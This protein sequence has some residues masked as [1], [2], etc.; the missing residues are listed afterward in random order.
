MIPSPKEPDFA[1]RLT[2]LFVELILCIA[3]VEFAIMLL[4]PRLAP[5]LSDLAGSIVDTTSLS[6]ITGP[7][8]IWRAQRL[9]LGMTSEPNFRGSTLALPL[10]IAIFG[11]AITALMVGETW[12]DL[13]K[14]RIQRFETTA[15]KLVIEVGHRM[16]V[17]M[18]G[19][20]GAKGLVSTRDFIDRTTFRQYFVALD[21]TVRHPGIRSMALVEAVPRTGLPAFGSRV[22]AS[23]DTSFRVR[24]TGTLPTALIVSAFEPRSLGSAILGLD[25]S[26]DSIRQS[27]ILEAATT[28]QPRLSGHVFLHTDPLHRPA[29]L[30]FAPVCSRV[31]ERERI[32]G[33][34]FTGAVYESYVVSELLS[35]ID[36][37]GQGEVDLEIFDG[38]DRD[39][40]NLVFDLDGRRGTRSPARDLGIRRT[41]EVAGRTLVLR[42]S[43][44]PSLLQTTDSDTPWEIAGLGL[45]LS[46]LLATL[47]WSVSTS[48]ARAREIAERRTHELRETTAEL[49]RTL[50]RNSNLLDS[51]SRHAVLSSSDL[52]GTILSANDVFCRISG[53][54]REELVGRNHRILSSGLHSREFWQGMHREIREGRAWR[55]DIRNRR[56]DGSIYWLDTLIIPYLDS[57]GRVENLQTI[58]FDITRRM[59]DEE[60]LRRTTSLLESVLRCSSEVAIVATDLGGTITLFNSGA[61][62][63][64]GYE[65]SDVV[66]RHSNV[67]LHEMDELSEFCRNLSEAEGKDLGG[68]EALTLSASRGEPERRE[69]NL[70]RKDG[71]KVPVSMVVTARLGGVDGTVEGFVM[72]SHD[73]SEERRREAELEKAKL[74]AEAASVAKSA[75][76]AN[77]SHEI[78]T[79]MN[80]VLGMTNVLL[81]KDLGPDQRRTAEVIRSSA[82]SLLALLNDILDFS[83]IEAGKLELESISFDL[84]DLLDEVHDLMSFRAAE[85]GLRLAT[86]FHE[87]TP[88]EFVGDPGRI[89]QILVNLV[90]NAVKFTATGEV[91]VEVGA[92]RSDPASASIRFGV[93]DTGVGIP[94]EKVVHLFQAFHQADSSTTRR[95]GG[96]GLGLAICRQLVDLMGGWIDAESEE[97]KGS[98]FRFEIPLVRDGEGDSVHPAESLPEPEPTLFR[99]RVLV[100]EDNLVNQMVARAVLEA[101]GLEVEVVENGRLAID[102]LGASRYDLVFMDM[103]MPVL[104]GLEA[105]RAWRSG[106]GGATEIDV[107]VVALTANAME[108]DR[109]AC[110]EAGLVDFLT[111]P[112]TDSELRSLLRRWLLARV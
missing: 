7:F 105:T 72:I 70:V 5:G 43:A 91:S 89:R 88:R 29:F 30:L 90:G 12:T 33:T 93:R 69:W 101:K 48:R 58:R 66:G 96:T 21:P 27:A 97:G 2:R 22:R 28:G 39:T 11:L 9:A 68:F 38:D 74:G 46:T 111:K 55:G 67:L 50:R 110:R 81:A 34:E 42:L 71:R 61:Q 49:E 112:F 54:P 95:F 24:S 85:K 23:G 100:A 19:L 78:R 35:G 4:L 98:E 37:I 73:I 17:A 102:A 109:K 77:M 83:K 86:L 44:R 26:E 47:V 79:P 107:P 52:G 56:K 45:V 20:L 18:D 16:D 1:P 10:G 51:I 62:N 75:F 41:L 53:F 104:G 82:E 106:S 84:R 40:S 15:N 87:G 6:L 31:P 8:M 65:A 60:R 63:L 25:F 64:L 76:L 13:R 59:E 92:T 57:T 99:G 3:G 32:P 103:Q 80:G 14:A 36:S 94:S 108:E